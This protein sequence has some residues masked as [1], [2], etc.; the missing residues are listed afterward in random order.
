MNY[1]LNQQTSISNTELTVYLE[2]IYCAFCIFL[3]LQVSWITHVR[4]LL[5]CCSSALDT[6]PSESRQ[7]P[8]DS[9]SSTLLRMLVTFT[10][11]GT[12]ALKRTVPVDA[13]GRLCD[14]W[15]VHLVQVGDSHKGC[16]YFIKNNVR[17]ASHFF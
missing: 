9:Q 8:T 11:C 12:W 6:E 15:M 4:R 7:V 16:H 17:G 10:S 3:L 5:L 2:R 14:N 13:M 1:R